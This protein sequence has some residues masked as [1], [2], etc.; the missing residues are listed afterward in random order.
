MTLVVP[1]LCARIRMVTVM[2]PVLHRGRR[3]VMEIGVAVGS[4]VVAFAGRGIARGVV[5]AGLGQTLGGA[6]QGV[7][8]LTQFPKPE[9]VHQMP[10]KQKPDAIRELR[11]LRGIR[12]HR[13]LPVLGTGFK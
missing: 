7:V 3:F 12:P 4:I 10:V 1:I 6:G 8:L 9:T 2:L 13:G 5:A 11:V